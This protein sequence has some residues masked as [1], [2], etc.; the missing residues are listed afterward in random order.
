MTI[1]DGAIYHE[2]DPIQLSTVASQTLAQAHRCRESSDVQL[3]MG[4]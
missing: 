2:D 1:T 4:Q 3:L